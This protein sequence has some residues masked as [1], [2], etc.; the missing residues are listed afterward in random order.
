[1]EYSLREENCTMD[2]I[3]SFVEDISYGY[4]GAEIKL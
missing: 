4:Y 1:M 3:A 2:E